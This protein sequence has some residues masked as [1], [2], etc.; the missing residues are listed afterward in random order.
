MLRE[1]S[2]RELKQLLDR[3]EEV[4]VLDVRE[5]TELVLAPL[6][7]AR[8]VPMREVPGRL[9]EIE[10]D[11]EIVV[12]CHHGIRS[13]QVAEFLVRHGFPRVANLVGGIDAWSTTVD[14]KVPRY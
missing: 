8:H 7:G 12:L 4:I 14:P 11:K 1:I 9:G 6:A 10:R 3:G 5:P 2:P 13:A